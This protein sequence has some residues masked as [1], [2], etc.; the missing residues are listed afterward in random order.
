MG[1]ALLV[2]AA[3][4]LGVLAVPVVRVRMLAGA[5]PARVAAAPPRAAPAASSAPVASRAAAPAQGS[6]A[7]AAAPAASLAPAVPAESSPLDCA[8]LPR[9]PPAGADAARTP[10]LADER[11]LALFDNTPPPRPP[12]QCGVLVYYHFAKAGGTSVR[13]AM[14]LQSSEEEAAMLPK[15]APRL[16]PDVS[17]K[18]LRNPVLRSFQA[19]AGSAAARARYPRVYVECHAGCNFL[20]LAD[21]LDA[22]RPALRAANC[23]VRTA[24]H[25]REPSSQTVSAWYYW[26]SKWERQGFK[27]VRDFVR[28]LQPDHYYAEY[29]FGARASPRDLLRELARRRHGGSALAGRGG[30]RERGAAAAAAEDARR[31]GECAPFVRLASEFLGGVDV[32]GTTHDWERV[33]LRLAAELRLPRLGPRSAKG[34][35]SCAAKRVAYPNPRAGG[36]CQQWAVCRETELNAS[37]LRAELRAGKLRCSSLLY[38]LWRPRLAAALAAYDASLAPRAR[39]LRDERACHLRASYFCTWSPEG[40]LAAPAGMRV[41]VRVRREGAASAHARRTPG[42]AGDRRRDVGRAADSN[43]R[44]Q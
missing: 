24:A 22:A 39:A 29:L 44:E 16:D 18:V 26:T 31:Y 27:G 37:A 36:R 10:S 38:E 2:G 4:M 23:T 35:R 30:A 25:L 9:K 11:R 17:W 15:G 3:C 21:A 20:R 8:A 12:L 41:Q 6:G 5:R 7:P 1:C 19:W 13:E 14:G 32:L 40:A 33:W 28:W 43:R 42:G 34:V